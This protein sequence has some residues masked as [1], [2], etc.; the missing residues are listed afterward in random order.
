M[1]TINKSAL[2]KCAHEYGNMAD[3]TK[4]GDRLEMRKKERK[5]NKHS[6]YI[7]MQLKSYN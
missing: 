7:H 4:N 1:A 2:A 5:A 3:L 6:L